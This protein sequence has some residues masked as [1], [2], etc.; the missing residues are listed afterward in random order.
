M[1]LSKIQ[2]GGIGYKQV[3]GSRV[4]GLE[5]VLAVVLK[6]KCKGA[7]MHICTGFPY[8]VNPV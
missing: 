1:M 6:V 5:K 7:L 8:P 2:E 4:W 3:L